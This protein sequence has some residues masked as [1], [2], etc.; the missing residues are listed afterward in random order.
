MQSGVVC[1]KLLDDIMYSVTVD[2]QTNE[3][4]DT[5]YSV[6]SSNSINGQPVRTNKFSSN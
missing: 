6:V 3:H 1:F 5:A 2:R 4:N